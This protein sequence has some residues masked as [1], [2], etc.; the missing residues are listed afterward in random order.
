MVFNNAPVLSKLSSA[1]LAT[2]P[3]G[4]NAEMIQ[5]SPDFL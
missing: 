4:K 2:E 1:D 5:T 3:F